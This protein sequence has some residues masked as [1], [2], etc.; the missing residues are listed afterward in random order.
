M[1]KLMHVYCKM[2]P[3]TNDDQEFLRI[4][5]TQNFIPV[6]FSWSWTIDVIV[7]LSCMNAWLT[8]SNH[9]TQS[10]HGDISALKTSLLEGFA[11][12]EEARAQSELNRD[13]DYLQLLYKKPLDPR[14][15]EQLKVSSPP[16]ITRSFEMITCAESVFLPQEIRRLY[17][18]VKF[19]MEDVNDVLDVEWEKHL[20]KKKKQRWAAVILCFITASL[21]AWVSAFAPADTWSSRKEKLCLQ[22]WPITWTS[23]TSRNSVLTGW[24]VTCTNWG[25]TE[26]RQCGASPARHPLPPQDRGESARLPH[27][28]S[29]STD[30]GFCW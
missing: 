23:S 17:Q 29:W 9:W 12:A 6:S 15:E 20:E 13:K 1:I 4:V 5:L 22:H 28:A 10:L 24:R 2:V 25:S 19:A 30:S 11:G 7:V 27:R 14:R 18:Y 21:Y 8:N 16:L 3:L 26:G